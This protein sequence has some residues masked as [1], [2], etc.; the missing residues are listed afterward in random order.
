MEGLLFQLSWLY[1][2]SAQYRW[3]WLRSTSPHSANHSRPSRQKG[4]NIKMR[5]ESVGAW[6][7]SN[8]RD[9]QSYF[10]KEAK[11][12]STPFHD[13]T[14]PLYNENAHTGD[15]CPIKNLWAFTPRFVLASLWITVASLSNAHLKILGGC[16]IPLQ[17]VKVLGSGP[18]QC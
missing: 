17:Q 10:P 8:P 11:I 18:S 16:E 12:Y 7:A 15:P 6:Q 9:Q 2:C 4:L 13:K 3:F 5:W 14:R 1:T